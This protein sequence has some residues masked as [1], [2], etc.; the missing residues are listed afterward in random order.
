MQS[1]VI[2]EYEGL[3]ISN[4]ISSNPGCEKHKKVG[5]KEKSVPESGTP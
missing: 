3:S 1:A 2:S 4:S 5:G